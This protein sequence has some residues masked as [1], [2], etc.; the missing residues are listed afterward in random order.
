MRKTTLAICGLLSV[1]AYAQDSLQTIVLKQ[2]VVTGTKFELQEEKS[3]KTIVKLGQKDIEQATGKTLG[4][5]LQEVPGV[6]IDGNFGAP[7]SNLSYYVRGGR[8]KN[9]LILIDGVP[10]NDPSSIN[11]EYDLRY[12]PLAQ[13]ESIEIFKGGLSTLYGTSASAGVISIKLKEAGDAFS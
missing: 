7:G 5:L 9:T 8:N 2:V 3:G 10:L 4:D 6:Q 11:A 1:S 12:I 13:V